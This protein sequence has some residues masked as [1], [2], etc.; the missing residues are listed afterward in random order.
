VDGV[1]LAGRV[2]L[3][4][5][6]ARGIGAAEARLFT[7]SGATVVAADMA[8]LVEELGPE[9]GD[10]FT[11]TFDVTDEDAWVTAI[12]AVRDRCGS[13]DGL[14]NNAGIGGPTTPITETLIADYRR[15]VDVNQLGTFLGLKHAAPLL[16]DSGGGSI[17]NVSS[18]AGL[19]G[20][21]HSVGY[22]ASKWAVRGISKTAALELGPWG[23]RVNTILPG[24]IDTRLLSPR[25]VDAADAYAW[26][27]IAAG[28][29]GLPDEVAR[30][31]RFLLSDESSYC[32]GGEFA[33]DGGYSAR[34]VGLGRE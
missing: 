34:G 24:G 22:V 30:V 11:L 14:V 27:R 33:V 21:E 2:V 29:P 28:R 17:V 7:A 5:G 32:T 31:A 16:R 15:V 18:V 26:D 13:L 25:D 6:A 10:G 4:T 23:I 9:L 3:V 1:S 20:V 19:V 8:P 12:A